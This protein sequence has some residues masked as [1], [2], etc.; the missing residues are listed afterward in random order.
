MDG[1]MDGWMDRRMDRQIDGW[2]EMFILTMHSIHFIYGY[3]VSD[4]WTDGRMDGLIGQ[5][6]RWMDTEN[7][8]R[9]AINK[10]DEWMVRWT[11]R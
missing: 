8:H 6:D 9:Q 1:W 7:P 2:M 3:V 5:T 10:L 4:G 11:D